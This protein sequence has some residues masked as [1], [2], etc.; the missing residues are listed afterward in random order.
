MKASD[1]EVPGS[2][3][4]NKEYYKFKYSY[5]LNIDAIIGVFNFEGAGGVHTVSYN[6]IYL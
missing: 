3:M 2:V 6:F 5:V 1:E 4:L